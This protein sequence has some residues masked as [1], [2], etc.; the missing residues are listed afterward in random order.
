MR[1]HGYYT[2]N[3]GRT[4]YLIKSAHHFV[5]ICLFRSPAY[6]CRPLCCSWVAALWTILYFETHLQ[7]PHRALP[8]RNTRLGFIAGHRHRIAVRSPCHSHLGFDTPRLLQFRRLHYQNS[9]SK[10]Y[11]IKSINTYH[12]LL[13]GGAH[14]QS[15]RK[16]QVTLRVFRDL[17]LCHWL[18]ILLRNSLRYLVGHLHILNPYRNIVWSRRLFLLVR[19]QIIVTLCIGNNL[20]TNCAIGCLLNLWSVMSLLI[21]WNHV[22][23]IS[24]RPL[25]L[26]ISKSI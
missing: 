22:F 12:L 26:V 14:L 24:H 3:I 8:H 11:L 17:N 21:L 1:A 2:R 20:L 16:L 13:F 7:P 9:S 10:L 19:L 15:V 18:K 4:W 5:L 25:R 6:P 23:S